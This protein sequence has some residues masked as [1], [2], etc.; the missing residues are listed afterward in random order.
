MVVD[1]QFIISTTVAAIYQSN[2]ERK[3]VLQIIT[4]A[5]IGSEQMHHRK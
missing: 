4:I 2:K 3:Q 5:L 1:S